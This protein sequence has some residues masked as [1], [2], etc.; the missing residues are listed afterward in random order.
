VIQV[1]SRVYTT[2]QKHRKHVRCMEGCRLCK[3]TE[4]QRYRTT[5]TYSLIY[6]LT[7]LL[8]KIVFRSILM[9]QLLQMSV[10]EA[11]GLR[12]NIIQ[13]KFLFD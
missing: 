5:N 13:V 10:F 12:L 2:V 7:Y 1:R 3:Y 8:R 6:L 9:N 11:I 4:I